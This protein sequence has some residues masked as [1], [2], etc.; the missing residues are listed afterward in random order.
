MGR[1]LTILV[2]LSGVAVA[3]PAP[4]TPPP[5]PYNYPDGYPPPPPSPPPEDAE[6]PK[7]PKAGDFNAGGQLRFPNGPDE[8]GEHAT[9]NW[10]AFDA[11]GKYYL[12]PS[13]TV[14][15]EM[16]LAVKKPENAMVRGATVDPR[17][18]GGWRVTLDARL[19]K[20]DVPLAP[21]AKDSEIGLLLSGL[22][23][24]EGAVLLSEKD[25]P[26]FIGDFKPGF[27]G[28]LTIKAKVSTLV[29]F[30]LVPVVAY[31]SGTAES[32][33]VLQLPTSLILKLGSLLKVSA[34]VGIF[35]GDDFKFGG[36]SG[37]RISLGA[38]I[39]VKIGPILAHA[40]TGFASLLTGDDTLYPTIGDSLYID[41]NAKYVK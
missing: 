10:V 28:G 7:E 2:T 38:A 15:G 35:T 9:F 13:V 4:P 21:K 30:S 17:M 39:D 32:I 6:Q 11:K 1:V 19:P 22:Y 37:G 14:S 5:S 33:T 3:Q 20:I 36:S 23:M 41:L 16:P 27:S 31:Q 24:R 26:L 34:D 18:I 12:L 8:A 40:G 29:D 25:F